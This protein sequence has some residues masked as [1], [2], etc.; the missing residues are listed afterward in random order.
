MSTIAAGS[1]LAAQTVIPLYAGFWRRG[2]AMLVD[3]LVLLVP[4]L[5][6]ALVLPGGWLATIAQLA[7]NVVYY[8]LMHSSASQATLGKMAFGIKVTG[9]DGE[10]IGLGRAVAR[11]FA[12]WLSAILLCI[13]LLMA[14]FT[15]K[16]MALHDMICGTLVAN[17]NASAEAVREGGDTMPLTGGVWAVI[18]LMLLLPF[19]GGILAAIAIP[20][21]QDYTIRAKVA[22]VMTSS[23][24]LRNSVEQAHAQKRSWATGAAAIESRFAQEAQITAE[25]H[26]VVTLKDE[27]V[28]GGRIRYVP[29]DEGG[30][31][32]WKC[33]GE[34]VPSKY[35]PQSCRQ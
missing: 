5:V 21:Y 7:V 3:G 11:V 14:A 23:G 9:L 26:V 29:T 33:S 15:G 6:V 13:G 34:S 27:V 35:L 32:Q 31:V 30:R 20:A 10:R 19:G 4:S 8:S 28:R 24:A 2:A 22:D 16:K 12:S 17:K 18:V 25:G 1:T